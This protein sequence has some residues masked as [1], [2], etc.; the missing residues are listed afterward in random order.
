TENPQVALVFYWEPLCRQIRIEGSAVKISEKESEEYFRTRAKD[1]Q[2]AAVVSKHGSIIENKETATVTCIMKP[3]REIGNL[4]VSTKTN[5][6]VSCYLILRS[7]LSYLRPFMYVRVQSPSF[8][9]LNE[10]V[11]QGVVSL[12]CPRPF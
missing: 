2:L 3:F 6:F 8:A 11:Q 9:L 7:L 1:A 4:K 10:Q 12:D 5:H